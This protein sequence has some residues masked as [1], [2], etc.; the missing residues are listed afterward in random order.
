MVSR[1]FDISFSSHGETWL[2][3]YFVCACVHLQF[4]VTQ[5]NFRCF[6]LVASNQWCLYLFK[7]KVEVFV[8]LQSHGLIL[9]F[10]YNIDIRFLI[11]LCCSDCIRLLCA[12]VAAIGFK[13]KAS[14]Q[15]HQEF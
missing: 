1:V 8:N 6:L 15:N 5:I 7:K 11:F 13:G 4:V 12:L 10:I 9:L 3:V 14:D 2:L